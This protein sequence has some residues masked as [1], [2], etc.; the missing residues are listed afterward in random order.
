MCIVIQGYEGAFFMTINNYFKNLLPLVIPFFLLAVFSIFAFDGALHATEP[1]NIVKTPVNDI[2]VPNKSLL[3]LGTNEVKVGTYILNV[4][5]LEVASG[6]WVVDF[7]VWFIWEG[8]GINP[9]NFEIMNG[10]VE[11][12]DAA[13]LDTIEVEGRKFK[14]ASHRIVATLTNDLNF[15]NYPL[16]IQKLTIE[17]E[18]REQSIDKMKYTINPLE[19]NIDDFVKIQGWEVK[20]KSCSISTH[21]Y[22]TTFGYDDDNSG[23]VYSRY[24]FGL[25]ISRPRFSSMLKLLLPLSI[26]LSL[27][28]LSFALSPDKMSQRISLGISTV[29]TSV[30]YH[31]NLTSAI[32]QVSYLTL[33][34]RLMISCYFILFCSLISTIYLIRFVD[35]QQLEKA[36]KI[37]R[38]LGFLVPL[39]GISLI[40]SQFYFF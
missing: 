34:D 25:K 30:A 9:M 28:F 29:F 33:A 36:E 38:Y 14:W 2:K 18:D 19:N 23:L 16:D 6:T 21:T 17:I 8:E 13:V 31:I 26:I 27:S 5:K 3:S 12:K 10:A 7:Y 1:V 15:K 37:N 35:S 32:P 24:I 40:V 20:E 22:K 4:R 11:F 39:F